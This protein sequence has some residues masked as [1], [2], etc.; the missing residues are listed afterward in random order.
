MSRHYLVLFMAR[1]TEK[2][3]LITREKI[4]HSA[5]KLFRENGIETTSVAEVM[6]AAGLTHGGFYRHFE[7]KEALVVAAITEAFRSS[8]LQVFN[9]DSVATLDQ[10]LAYIQIY[11]SEEHLNEPAKGCPMPLLG[12]EIF[13]GSESWRKALSLGAT[14]AIKKLVEGFSGTSKTDG[15]AILSTLVGTLV[16]ARAV[17]DSLLRSQLISAAEQQIKSIIA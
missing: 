15:L 9:L 13:R 7:S 3:K 17:D 11:L 14:T 2:D 10:S 16:L 4:I 5:A 12:A 8:G 1:K 6:A